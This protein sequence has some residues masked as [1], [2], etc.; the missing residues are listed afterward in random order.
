MIKANILMIAPSST[1]A[2]VHGSSWAYR[3]ALRVQASAQQQ[4]ESAPLLA[5]NG[6][7]RNERRRA[8]CCQA[9]HSAVLE[10]EGHLVEV[11]TGAARLSSVGWHR[12]SSSAGQLLSR[13]RHSAILSGSVFDPPRSMRVNRP[14]ASRIASDGSG[15]TPSGVPPQE[16][17]TVQ[18]SSSPLALALADVRAVWGC[19]PDLHTCQ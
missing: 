18:F 17:V 7:G 4:S 14:A 19:H 13:T 10:A 9:C 5:N 16:G 12:C 15:D 11:R 8:L 6:T 1:A 2:S 3:G